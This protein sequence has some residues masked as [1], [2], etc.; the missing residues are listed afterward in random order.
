MSDYES[1]SEELL[2]IRRQRSEAANVS[3]TPQNVQRLY[4][5]R[6]PKRDSMDPLEPINTES[7]DLD[8]DEISRLATSANPEENQL[9]AAED[10]ED[11]DYDDLPPR[12]STVGV[13]NNGTAPRTST[14]SQ[15]STVGTGAQRRTP[16]VSRIPIPIPTPTGVGM[17]GVRR[18][19]IPRPRGA[20]NVTRR[21]STGGKRPR[22]PP[23]TSRAEV[24][25]RRAEVN[26]RHAAI[27]RSRSRSRTPT[28]SPRA[29]TSTAARPDDDDS[30]DSGSDRGS[31]RGGR[32]LDGD[33]GHLL[34]QLRRRTNGKHIAGITHTDTITTTYKDGRRPTVHR[35]SQS[36]S[37]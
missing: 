3:L 24:D 31:S 2:Q 36:A 27:N 29:S 15:P 28:P 4:F 19:L 22:Q 32:R 35:T 12:T 23:A 30:D 20:L 37:S 17:G 10:A 6:I 13:A 9:R 8:F 11:N 21:R 33:L 5:G 14:S 16:M 7:D 1:E 25:Q 34:A 26:Q 18:R